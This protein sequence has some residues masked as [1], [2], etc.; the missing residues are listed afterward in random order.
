VFDAAWPAFLEAARVQTGDPDLPDRIR[1]LQVLR[2]LELLAGS[3]LA[4][5]VRPTVA[6]SLRSSLE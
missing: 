1:A 6:A 3:S 4:P 5:E 2:M